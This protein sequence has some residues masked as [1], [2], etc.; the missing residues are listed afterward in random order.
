[1]DLTRRAL[2]ARGALAAGALMG[3]SLLAPQVVFAGEEGEAVVRLRLP[4]S[5]RIETRRT[6]ELIGLEGPGGGD[7]E[8]RALGVDGRW[9]EWLHLHPAED[10]GP[11]GGD[12]PRLS[13]PVWTGP[14]RVF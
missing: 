1:M 12:A 9:T 5:G 7:A 8:V 6:F 10:H 2:I 13:D 11:D 4:R 14:A 3:G